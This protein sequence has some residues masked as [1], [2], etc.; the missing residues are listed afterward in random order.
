MKYISF[1][2]NGANGFGAVINDRDVVDLTGKI[3]GVTTLR[4]L[5]AKD[6]QNKAAQFVASAKPDFTLDTVELLPVIPNPNKIVC[7]GINYVA[8]AAE[9][10][11]TIGQ[12]P[13]IFQRWADS[14]LAHGKPIL[15]PKVSNEFDFE[16]ELAVVIGKGGGHI[17]KED[18]MSHVAGYTCFNDASARDWQFHTHQY[19][20]G[21]NFRST[22]ALG[23]WMISAEDV[24]DYRQISLK[25]F[26]NGQ[27]MQEGTL[28]QLAFDVPSLISYVSKAVDWQ[29]GDILATGTPSGI[30]FKRKPPIFLKHG[31]I[32]EV[33]IDKIG[34][35]S[36]PV[37][38]E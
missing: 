24:P 5:L 30:G 12:Y 35:L 29:P 17:A 20:M 32:F 23:P 2:K 15:K 4:E 26:L 31:D 36:N 18:A 34:T 28:D 14:L 21:K 37:V 8:H 3:D 11:R 13:V 33:V 7:V 22:G 1:T 25:G 27:Q 6:L 16:A 19:G 9:A 10:G 38:N